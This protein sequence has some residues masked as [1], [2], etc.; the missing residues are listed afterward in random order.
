[1]DF[2]R[3]ADLGNPGRVQMNAW[4]AMTG[5]FEDYRH[6]Y[7]GE[8]FNDLLPIE[9][10][11]DEEIKRFPVGLNLVKMLAQ[12]QADALFG[13][14]DERILSFVPAA[15]ETGEED[16]KS[17]QAAQQLVADILKAS[18]ANATF[19]QAALTREVYGGVPLMVK[20]VTTYPYIKWIPLPLEGFYPIWNPDNEDEILEAYIL[21]EMSNDQA[22]I[23]YGYDQD[24][25]IVQRVEHWT[26]TSY[27]TMLD[28]KVLGKYTGANPWGF[29]PF[30]YAPR[31]R[32]DNWWGDPLTPDIIPIQDELNDRIADIGEALNYNA[33]PTRWGV[34]LPR[35]FKRENFPL[36]PNALWD[37][38]RQVGSMPPAQVGML[39]AKNPIPD[40]AF[41][42][43][44]FLYDWA[45]TSSFAP[46]IVF[47]E[48]E[49]SQRSGDTLEIR[50]WSLVKYVRRSRANLSSAL[51][52]MAWMSGV[53]YQ[54]KGW[55]GISGYAVR[56]LVE[57][58]VV[59]AYAPVLP[60]DHQAIV[61]EM[62]KLRSLE[63][64]GI[65]LETMQKDLGRDSGEVERII[66]ELQS[67][68]LHPKPEVKQINDG[69]DPANKPE[70]KR[71]A[72]KGKAMPQPK[73]EDK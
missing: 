63:V 58:K 59:P 54:Q 5:R 24:K 48:D 60:R 32:T 51:N 39:E 16:R 2:P 12:A 9:S 49:G 26:P 45:R 33:H 13:E 8:V 1:M 14:W 61:D 29:T 70:Q 4:E 73:K 30:A 10:P 15:D 64:P 23:L 28:G 65:S 69:G 40:Q 62:I 41:K 67:E 7:S 42:H 47:G 35:S 50:M 34:N 18:N 17:S 19:W 20:A 43:L 53:I 6:Y 71:A 44:R 11:G 37:L 21:T 36:G 66:E 68:E 22:R 25:E 55:S 38:G 52:R 72:E 31:V 57:N 27:K 46:P 3:W 56:R